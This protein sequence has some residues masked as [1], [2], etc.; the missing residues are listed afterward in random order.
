MDVLIEVWGAGRGVHLAPRGDEH[1]MGDD[2]PRETF[3]Y[4]R[5]EQLGQNVQ[6]AFFTREHLAR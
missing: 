2:D 1:D 5:M 4:V 6:I 3:G